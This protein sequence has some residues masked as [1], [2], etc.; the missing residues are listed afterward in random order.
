MHWSQSW[1]VTSYHVHAKNSRS[2]AMHNH[3]VSP[4]SYGKDN[5]SHDQDNCPGL[6]QNSLMLHGIAKLYTKFLPS[7]NAFKIINIIAKFQLLK[8]I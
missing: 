1:Q 2:K 7:V 6:E 8:H 4:I 3:T 5:S